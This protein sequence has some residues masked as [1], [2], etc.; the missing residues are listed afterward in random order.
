MSGIDRAT[1]AGLASP[2]TACAVRTFGGALG[3]RV[4]YAAPEQ[5]LE[6]AAGA[7]RESEF[8]R[9]DAEVEMEAVVHRRAADAW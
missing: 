1:A 3:P 8:R 6:E 7:L 9:K 4:G 5:V 2:G